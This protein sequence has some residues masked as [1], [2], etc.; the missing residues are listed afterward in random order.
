MTSL[1]LKPGQQH[2]SAM[3]GVGGV[4]SGIFFALEGNQTLGREESRSGRFLDRR[5]YCKLH[6]VSHYVK[7]LLGTDFV[8]I[9]IGRVGDDQ[10]GTTLLGEMQEA[11]LDLRYMERA[12]GEQTLF[13]VCFVY[14]DGSGGNLTGNRSACATVDSSLVGRAEPEM[15]TFAGHG[16]ALAMP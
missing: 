6:I 2:F 11:G 9:P 10:V 12:A 3:I 16:I 13:A 4:G 1:K 5:D 8:V 15:A 14:P 7:R